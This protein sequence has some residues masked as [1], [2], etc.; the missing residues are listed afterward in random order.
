MEL[1][2]K[3]VALNIFRAAIGLTLLAV[4]LTKPPRSLSMRMYMGLFA[5]GLTVAGI[6]IC[7]QDSMHVLD[8]L[9]YLGLGCA[10][11][12][13]ALEIDEVQLVQR[14]VQNT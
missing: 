9:L 12:V 1:A 13:E 6:T 11:G 5:S 2:G 7:L 10:L 3:S 14:P 4:L 8:A